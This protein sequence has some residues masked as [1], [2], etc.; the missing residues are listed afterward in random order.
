MKEFFCYHFGLLML[1]EVQFFFLDVEPMNLLS[2]TNCMY[3]ELRREI[4]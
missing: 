4:V 1:S 2:R 3:R